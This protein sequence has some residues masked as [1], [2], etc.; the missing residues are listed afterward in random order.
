MNRAFVAMCIISLIF[1]SCE[2]NNLAD[3]IITNESDFM[4]TFKFSNTGEKHLENG[5]SVTFETKAFQHIEFYTP[6]KRVYFTFQS[7]ND[8]YTGQFKTRQFWDLKVNNTIGEL[9]TLSADGWMDVM[10]DINPGYNDDENHNGLI[11]NDT[12]NFSVLTESGFPA[13]AKFNQIDSAFY[14]TIQWSP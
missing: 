11:Y 12:P 3:T 1:V 14:V 9:A 5:E 6:D 4:V 8:G 7:N 10:A 2:I 13:T